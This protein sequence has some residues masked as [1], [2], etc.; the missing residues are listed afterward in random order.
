[1]CQHSFIWLTLSMMRKFINKR[2]LVRTTKILFAI[3]LSLEN[4]M[5]KELVVGRILN[6]AIKIEELK[7]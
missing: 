5:S 3:F 1:M 4:M 6:G 7:S 2:D